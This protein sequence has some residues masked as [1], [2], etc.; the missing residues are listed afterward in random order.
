MMMTVLMPQSGGRKCSPKLRLNICP[1][2]PLRLPLIALPLLLLLQ[3]RISL[4]TEL[5][6]FNEA[7]YESWRAGQW[8]CDSKQMGTPGACLNFPY[9]VLEI[10]LQVRASATTT[11]AIMTRHAVVDQLPS[12]LPCPT[13]VST[14]LMRYQVM[15]RHAQSCLMMMPRKASFLVPLTVPCRTRPILRRGYLSC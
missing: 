11:P 10:K 8:C 3:V 4:D 13:A 6:L 12:L 2:P 5:Q 15:P 1:S 9:A 7:Q 14:Q